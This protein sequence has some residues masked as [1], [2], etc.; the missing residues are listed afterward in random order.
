M[1]SAIAIM[2]GLL[3]TPSMAQT[4]HDILARYPSGNYLENLIVDRSGAVLFTNYFAGKVE[5]W[6]DGK[7]SVF[8][9][10]PTLPVNLVELD[11][12]YL[13][14]GHGVKFTEGAA[15]LAGSNRLLWLDRGGQVKRSIPLPE[16]V[17]GNG[18]IRSG[19]DAVLITDSMLGVIWRV[20]L[21]SGAMTKWFSDDRLKPDP[22]VPLG[23]GA[24][25]LRRM[26]SELVIT[27]SIASSVFRLPVSADEK[28]AGPL[29]LWAK[30][31][32]ADDLAVA[33]DGSIYLATHAK[34]VVRVSPE[35]KVTTVLDQD[36][37]GCTSVALSSDG[38]SLYV[39]G[40]GG[41]MEGEKKEA[42]L[43][44]MATAG[45]GSATH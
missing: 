36:V 44:R 39:L 40:T 43:V 41:L 9:E 28:P 13:L 26:G 30:T 22:K 6:R 23:P 38:R 25:G 29:T 24:N 2:L 8:A 21:T 14:L 42:T 10:V 5:I 7:A 31:P 16:A 3:T 18:M 1:R 32:G 17:F 12:G 4:P 11:D 20:D 33:A 19:S 35:G 15:K 27:S 34:S 45:A 37:D